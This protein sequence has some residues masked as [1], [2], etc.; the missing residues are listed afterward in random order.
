MLTVRNT[1]ASICR[2]DLESNAELLACELR[3]E[4]KKK[5]L[6]VVFYRPPNSDLAYI[7][8]FK[9][10]LLLA[11]KA[12]FEHTIICGGFNLPNIDWSTGTATTND[13]IH[14]YFT[15]TVKDNFLWQLVNFPTRINNTLDLILTN[16][17]E[18]VIKLA[19]F[20]DIFNSDHKILSFELNLHIPR[21]SK[22]K[23]SVYNFKKADWSGLKEL[24]S[25]TPWDLA[26]VHN[27]VNESLS[28][29]CDLFFSAVNEPI[30]KCTR[31]NTSDHPWIHSE[32][33]KKIKKKNIQRKKALRTNAPRDGEKFKQLRRETKQMIR[34]KKRRIS[35]TSYETLCWK[36]RRAFGRS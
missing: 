22:A 16:I 30:P 31:R 10:S 8:E 26:F 3:P 4:S 23:R 20:E 32:L 15:K 34:K 7:K 14:G 17:P 19:G 25:R 33:L 12:N 9:K 1:I 35:P 27:D 36:T 24:L 18:K 28:I 21:Q 6:V 29:W 5:V 11:S 13:V 2:K